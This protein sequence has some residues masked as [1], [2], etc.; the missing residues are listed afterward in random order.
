MENLA[1][2]LIYFLHI[3][4]IW[5]RDEPVLDQGNSAVVVACPITFSIC[6][7]SVGISV[8]RHI[9]YSF[10]CRIHLKGKSS[11]FVSP[12]SFAVLHSYVRCF[13]TVRPT[14]IKLFYRHSYY[15]EPIPKHSTLAAFLHNIKSLIVY[16]N[17]PWLYC[18]LII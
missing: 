2:K 7:S 18:C 11:Q 1:F 10:R 17:A 4:Y 5:Y 3:N 15:L 12:P 9:P 16:I 8:S 14:G 13:Q 6:P